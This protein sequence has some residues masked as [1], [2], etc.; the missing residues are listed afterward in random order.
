MV[1]V[2]FAVAPVIVLY[3]PLSFKTPPAAPSDRWRGI[4]E[5]TVRIPDADASRVTACENGNPYSVA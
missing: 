5:K 2:S 1:S 3:V 4:P